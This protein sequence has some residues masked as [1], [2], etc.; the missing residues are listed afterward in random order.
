MKKTY[1]LIGIAIIFYLF[2]FVD[3]GKK[4]TTS[5]QPP[6]NILIEGF[7]DISEW[8]LQE[9][10]SFE[11]DTAYKR[12]GRQS[13]K[14]SSINGAATGVAKTIDLDLSSMINIIFWVYI[15]VGHSDLKKL[16]NIRLIFAT[17]RWSKYFDIR[18]E[19]VFGSERWY[20]TEF[21]AGW[22]RFV[23]SKAALRSAGD[24]IW[25]DP[26]VGIQIECKAATG[27]DVSV[28]FDDLRINYTARAKCVLTFD[29]GL[30][31]VY[32]RAKSIMDSNG[33]TGVS[34]I[35]SDNVGK[36]GWM[37][38]AELETLR[39]A[40]W[41]ISN[42]TRSHK[43]LA[44]WWVSQKEMEEEIDDGYDWLVEN[45]FGNSAKFFC[46]P[47]GSYNDAVL[48]KVKERHKLARSVIESRF[49]PHFQLND[50]DIDFLIKIK[51]VRK[52][53]LPATV[54]GWIDETIDHGGLMVLMFHNIVDTP[55]VNIEYATEDFEEISDYLKSKE[56][57]IDVITFS[58]Y[59]REISE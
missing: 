10:G 17:E 54:K 35:N 7:E 22:N 3:C 33:Q 46:Y 37:T 30:K 5:I 43:T 29:D 58:D 28:S 48:Q 59:Y 34:F 38:K 14:L 39:D 13:I 47:K 52:D 51:G 19:L 1:I 42:H 25:S 56:A 23:I 16:D 53:A 21:K 32:G 40:G 11:A 49:Q 41:D 36:D 6:Q 4:S 27:E 24:A 55:S 9:G 26:I 18:L 45:G 8:T 31:G 57:D 20:F 2:L 44:A 15:H 12:E 50:D